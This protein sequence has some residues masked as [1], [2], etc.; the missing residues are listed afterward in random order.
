M[1]AGN[2]TKNCCCPSADTERTTDPAADTTELGAVDGPGRADDP[3]APRARVDGRVRRGAAGRGRERHVA[4]LEAGAAAPVDLHAGG[5]STVT[6][7]SAAPV[8]AER[9]RAAVEEAGYSL[10]A[11]S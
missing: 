9:V 4:G 7:S 11:A 6:V 5:V 3:L 10:A 8:D 1:P 2:A